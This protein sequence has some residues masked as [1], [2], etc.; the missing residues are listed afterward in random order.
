[1]RNTRTKKSGRARGDFKLNTLE[2]RQLLATISGTVFYDLDLDGAI[3]AGETGQAGWTIFADANGNGTLDGGFASADV[4][5]NIN[6][7][8]TVVSALPISGQAGTISD[9]NVSLTISHTFNSDLDIFLI[10]PNGTRIE[11]S[12]DNGSGGNGMNLTFDDQAAASITSLPDS[13]TA[14]A[15][16]TYRPET[17]LS[18]VN[19]LPFDG[20]WQLE[21]TDDAGQ[22][23]GAITGWSISFNNAAEAFTASNTSGAYSLT[24]PAGNFDVRL[25]VPPGWQ[26]H[27][28]NILVSVPTATSSITGQNFGVRQPPGAISGVVFGDYNNNGI[29]DAGEPGLGGRTVYI[30]TDNDSIFDNGEISMVTP[31]SGAYSFTNMV[32]GQKYVRTLLPAQWSQTSPTASL[33]DNGSSIGTA[34]ADTIASASTKASAP[35]MNMVADQLIISVSDRSRLT[36]ALNKQSNRWLRNIVGLSRGSELL[37]TSTASVLHV[38]L[39][40]GQNPMHI[41]TQLKRLAGMQWAQPNF[42]Y[43]DATDPREYTP[44]D[45]QYASQ[46][47][48]ATMKNNLAWDITEGAGVKVGITDDGVSIAHVDLSANI[49]TNTAE[50][51]ANGID[52]DA[53]GFIDDVNGWDFTNSTTYGTGDNNPNPVVSTDDHGTHVSG[54]VAART[55]NGVGVAGTAGK[56]TIVPLRFY[57]SG[58]WTSTVI[59]NTYKYAADNGIKIVSTS[60]NVDGFSS[61]IDSLYRTAVEYLYNNGVLHLN[62]A[63]NSGAANPVRQV[64]D[65]TLYVASTDQ[66]DGKSS[67]SNYGTGIDIAAPGGNILS[68]VTNNGYANYGGTSMATPNAAAVAALIWSK[69][70]TWTRDQV[71]AQLL[72]TT[73]NI[74]AVAG[75]ATFATLMGTGRVNSFRSVSET[76][77]AP[78]VRGVTGLNSG[79]VAPTSFTLRLFNVLDVNDVNNAANFTLTGAGDDDIFGTA[80]DLSAS[81]TRT[82]SAYRIGTNALNFAITGSLTAGRWRFSAISGANGLSD[83]FGTALDGNGDG[84]AGDNFNHEFILA[85][86]TAAHSITLDPGRNSI[87]RNFGTRERVAPRVTASVFQFAT[88]QRLVF[89]LTEP[90]AAVPLD[91]LVLTNSSTSSVVPTSNYSVSLG[92]GGMQLV[93][94][95]NTRLAD[96]NYVALLDNTKV[97]DLYGNK[98]DGDALAGTA[99]SDYSF[100]FFF[101]NGDFDRDTMVD[102]DD[103]LTISQNFGQTTGM[104]FATGDADY[105]GDVDFDDLLLVAQNFDTG[106]VQTQSTFGNTRIDDEDAIL[107]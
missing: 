59:F 4:P 28:A 18:A 56:A 99:A 104:T 42:A 33:I 97:L 71:A 13:G 31:A 107:G 30:D 80:D 5:K 10:A 105:D 70:P 78:K 58:S 60:Y 79:T 88:A 54:I 39:A 8:T 41:A 40:A 9:L 103:L 93:F 83:P 50:I 12:T 23:I 35:K 6:D 75:N 20:N 52:D 37:K 72:G 66:G 96:G 90:M 89:D 32:P 84:T 76:L 11:L 45:P 65:T 82:T 62:S 86:V 92:V 17:V 43:A 34:P 1:M 67:F 94:T 87:D 91:G 55:N 15:Q 46:Y 49:F 26:S 100:P 95:I 48:H 102:F 3:E 69:N 98:L 53:N 61:P 21:V 14:V 24:V 77:A 63:G 81:I 29:R 57:G 74:D 44:N 51:A 27:T 73:D 106:L 101:K 16:G 36:A 85:G 2:R 47:H 7:F 64:F 19:G 25:S 22:D 68:T 38:P